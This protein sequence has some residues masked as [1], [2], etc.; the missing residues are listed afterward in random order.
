MKYDCKRCKYS[1]N[2][3]S[4]YNRHIKS[5][6]HM[7]SEKPDDNIPISDDKDRLVFKCEKCHD[8]FTNRQSLSRHCLYRCKMSKTNENEI[9]ELKE[10]ISKLMNETCEMKKLITEYVKTTKTVNTNSHNTYNISI[11]NYLQ[12]TYPNAPALNGIIDYSK[13]EYDEEYDDL[14]D[15]IVYNY[16]NSCLNKYLGDFII[17][18]YKKSNPLD[19]SIWSSDTSRLTYIIKELLANNESIWNHD[20]KGLKIKT[21]II[22]PLL[23]Y[24]KKHIN[25]YWMKNLDHFK[26]ANVEQLNKFNN[27]YDSIYKIKKLINGD[28]L[29]N[30]IVKYI[31][32]HFCINRDNKNNDY[33]SD[34]ITYFIDE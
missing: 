20:Y 25:D 27:M 5:S 6:T 33:V 15:A 19:Q 4:N 18:S 24:I 29:G 30:D 1:T 10:T 7:S 2:D 16:N 17:C 13:L 26:T 9:I 11:K 28:I 22:D 32:P 23:Q 3:K 31:A 21:Y 12:Q 14:I 34:Y 8:F